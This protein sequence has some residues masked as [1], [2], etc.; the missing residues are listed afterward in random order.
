ME[1][2]DSFAWRVTRRM[3]AIDAW[4]SKTFMIP[5]ARHPLLSTGTGLLLL[6]VAVVTD[7]R[8][9]GILVS[10]GATLLEFIGGI[11][12]FVGVISCS[13]WVTYAWGSRKSK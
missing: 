5:A 4:M 7:H 12:V 13:V 9:H 2:F 3:G 8:Y 10:T 11:L 6:Y 1:S